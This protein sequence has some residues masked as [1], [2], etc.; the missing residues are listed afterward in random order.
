MGLS[1]AVP[2]VP[3]QRIDR[4]GFTRVALADTED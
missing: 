2:F 3:T 1:S 4:H